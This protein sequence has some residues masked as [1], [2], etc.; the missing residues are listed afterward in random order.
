MLSHIYR[1]SD[2]KLKIEERCNRL[3]YMSKSILGNP[4]LMRTSGIT[5]D[6][7]SVYVHKALV[8]NLSN[9]YCTVIWIKDAPVAIQTLSAQSRNLDKH[10]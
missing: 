7:D 3:T 8:G 4:L 2:G 5:S 9:R 1:S 6:Y 10:D